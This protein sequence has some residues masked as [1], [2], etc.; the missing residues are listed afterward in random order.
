MARHGFSHRRTTTRKKKNLSIEESKSAITNFFL[1][2]RLYQLSVPN[3][4]Y[5]EV[6]NRDQVPI[7]L[8]SSY[9]TTIDDKNKDVI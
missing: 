2:T 9:S 8:A 3:I 5:T 1:D 7:A 6:Y 4:S